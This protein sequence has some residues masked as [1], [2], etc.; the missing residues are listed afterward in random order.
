MCGYKENHYIGSPV[1]CLFSV[2]L[3]ESYL[4]KAL[5]LK[6]MCIFAP[7]IDASCR[8]MQRKHLYWS[9]P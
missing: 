7:K 5:V 8:A 3:K 4:K 2:F 6:K 1:I 9:A